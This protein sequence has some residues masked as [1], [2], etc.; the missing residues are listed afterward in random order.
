M[1]GGRERGRIGNIGEWMDEWSWSDR[2]MNGRWE[3][4]REEDRYGQVSG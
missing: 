1:D 3:K 2:Q 4:G